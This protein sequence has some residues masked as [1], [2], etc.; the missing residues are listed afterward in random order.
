MSDAQNSFDSSLRSFRTERGSIAYWDTGGEGYPLILLPGIGVTRTDLLERSGEFAEWVKH[1]TFNGSLRVIQ[2][3]HIGYGKSEPDK[4]AGFSLDKFIEETKSVIE[5]L[6][7]DREPTAVF[8][9]DKSSP[10]AIRSAAELST[11]SHLI[12]LHPCR[13]YAEHRE[14]AKL[15]GFREVTEDPDRGIQF[16]VAAALDGVEDFSRPQ[17]GQARTT[18]TREENQLLYEEILRD[19]IDP[20]IG[21]WRHSIDDDED[22]MD[23]S[24]YIPGV[25]VPTLIMHRRNHT[26]VPRELTDD[27]RSELPQATFLEP[28]GVSVFPWIGPGSR[29]IADQISRFVLRLADHRPG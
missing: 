29:E 28:D 9:F 4:R 5:H 10:L 26:I 8:G 20:T 7:I 2:F 14:R 18:P 12:L 15:P 3:D 24:R 19:T 23:A 1:L 21:R 27:L 22:L 13:S 6:A 17:A 11:V 16:L 25:R